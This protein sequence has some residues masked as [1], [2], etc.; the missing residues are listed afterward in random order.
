MKGFGKLLREIRKRGGLTQQA[1]A[2]K[3]RVD[4]SSIS[5]MEGGE[6]LPVRKVAVGLADALAIRREERIEFLSAADVL[7]AEDLEGFELVEVAEDGPRGGKQPSIVGVG[8]LGAG[9]SLGTILPRSRIGQQQIDTGSQQRD[10]T[11]KLLVAQIVAE[12]Q[13]TLSPE[14]RMLAERLISEN[15]RSV[16]EVLAKEQDK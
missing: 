8:A 9:V 11:I 14:Q 13:L 2:D 1:L 10:Q 4:D 6:F 7:S 15:A 5:K 3:V 12:G 16:C